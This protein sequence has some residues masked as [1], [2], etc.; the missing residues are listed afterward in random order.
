ML[1]KAIAI[2]IV[3]GTVLFAPLTARSG[4]NWKTVARSW[5]SRM[6]PKCCR[7]EQRLVLPTIATT[8]GK[9]VPCVSKGWW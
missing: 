3:L 4:G 9:N 1:S 8:P 7:P 5:R 2:V 6:P